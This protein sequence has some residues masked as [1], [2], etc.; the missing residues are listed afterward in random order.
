V[1]SHA[2]SDLGIS[3][4][5]FRASDL[6]EINSWHNFLEDRRLVMGYRFPV[7]EETSEIWLNDRLKALKK[8]T[9]EVYWAIRTTLENKLIG[10]VSLY[11]IDYL[12]R[13]SEIGIYLI[14][15]RG[16]GIG[17]AVIKECAERGFKD[18]N[19]NKIYCRVLNSNH[20]AIKS[21]EKSN[22]IHEGI[23][24]KHFWNGNEWEDI[25]LMSIIRDEI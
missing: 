7:S 25:R 4:G 12:N 18:L 17:S 8:D 23:L 19:L 9:T 13:N 15:Q 6:P 11:N 24:R 5:S 10:Y 3:L 2:L 16:K 22:F 20:S 21:F 14:N 1:S